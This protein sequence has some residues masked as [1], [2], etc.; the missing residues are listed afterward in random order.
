MT[1][2]S[3]L[4]VG[5]GAACGAW[6]RWWL[7]VRLNPIATALPVGTLAANW[8]GAYLMGVVMGIIAHHS[9]LPHETRLLIN[10]GFLGGLTTF[11]SFSGEVVTLFMREQIVLGLG[12]V[13]LHL[14]GSLALTALGVL[15]VFV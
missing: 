13:A 15:S 6:L 2:Y 14:V 11:S 10:T 12:L 5:G 4:A 1:P 8:I 9:S 7:A 3:F